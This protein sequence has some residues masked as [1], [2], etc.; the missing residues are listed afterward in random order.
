MIKQILF[1]AALAP[2]L[3]AQLATGPKLPYKVVDNWAKLPKGWNFGEVSGVAVDKN[4][5]VWVFNRGPHGV[6]EFDRDGKML[7][8]WPEVPIVSA[9]GIQTDPDGN[10][11]LVDVA[12]HA[13]MKFTREGKLLMVIANAGKTAGDNQSK[14]AFNR[15]TGLRFFPNGDFLVSDGYVNSR[16]A[17]FGKDGVWQMQWGSKGTG[18]GQFDLVH[19]VVLDGKGKVYVA[20]RS[21][22]R[23]QIFTEDG[24]FLSKWT[25]LGSPWGLAYSTKEN[26]MFLCDGVNNRV[27]KVDMNGKMLGEIGGGLGKI[28]GL[29]EFPHHMA[30]DSQGAIYVAEIRNWRV[31]K[32]VPGK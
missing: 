22:N 16:V 4:D 1:L 21:N 30:I 24:K 18:D 14:T 19:D 27:I 31:Q 28:P 9:H 7:Q 25:N 3:M 2:A 20:D 5:H 6:V 15:P 29:F 13:V 11:W 32:F 10:V 8:S 26:V 23:V 17:K 12:G